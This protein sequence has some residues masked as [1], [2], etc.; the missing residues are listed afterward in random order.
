MQPATRRAL[1]N[2]A[3]PPRLKPLLIVMLAIGSAP[4]LS[5]CR[6]SPRLRVTYS[7]RR[8]RPDDLHTEVPGG[9]QPCPGTP[10]LRERMS[11]FAGLCS[12]Y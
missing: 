12:G 3:D 10:P 6:S 11:I 7:P 2:R 5:I 8:V 9:A 1:D 4:E